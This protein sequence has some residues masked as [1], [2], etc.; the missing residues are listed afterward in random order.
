MLGAQNA[1]A[2]LRAA[3]CMGEPYTYQLVEFLRESL[4]AMNALVG[5][6]LYLCSSCRRVPAFCRFVCSSPDTPSLWLQQPSV[7][8]QMKQVEEEAAA[9]E[10]ERL[11]A[12]EAA[13]RLEEARQ[14][15]DVRPS[16]ADTVV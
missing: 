8:Q 6:A 2:K 4:Q 3:D 14:E 5:C 13:N 15:I 12:Q 10:R 9:R 11:R 16:P 1:E 7:F